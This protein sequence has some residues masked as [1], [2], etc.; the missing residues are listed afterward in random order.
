MISVDQAKEKQTK[1]AFFLAAVCSIGVFLMLQIL[2][3]CGVLQKLAPEMPEISNLAAYVLTLVLF[4][5]AFCTFLLVFRRLPMTKTAA[6]MEGR[7]SDQTYKRTF[8][9]AS[10][11]V[12][13]LLA[14]RRLF[15]EATEF[16][17]MAAAVSFRMFPLWIAIPLF[18]IVAGTAVFFALRLCRGWDISN[19]MLYMCT[20]CVLL[21][22]LIAVL[23]LDLF[24]GDIHHGVAYLESVYNVYYGVPY[25]RITMGI[26]G[27]Y[28]LFLAPVLHIFGGSALPL[29]ITMALL[30]C[31]TALL[32]MYCVWSLVENNC[33]RL[34]SLLMCC[35]CTLSMRPR[36]YWQLLPHRV[37]WPLIL[38]AFLLYLTKKDSWR[39]RD[40]FF[41][42]CL[43]TAA[44]VWNMESGLF[45]GIAFAAACMVRDWQ[46]RVWYSPKSLLKL[47][48][49]I[50][51]VIAT[52]AAAILIVNGYNYLCGQREWFLK[53]FFF[54]M[55][56]SSY[57]SDLL[58][59]DMPIGNHAWV[60]V[61]ILFG[62]LL[63]C[64]LYM[65]SFV[66]GKP[67]TAT[68]EA[69]KLAPVMMAVAMLGLCCF[70][71]YA[72]RAAYG[73]LEI[74]IQLAGIA[75]CMLWREFRKSL[76]QR[77]GT[78]EDCVKTIIS[79][80]STVL[81]ITLS[82]EAVLFSAPLLLRKLMYQHYD[83]RGYRQA[84]V[85]LQETI[86]E[87]TFAFGG[88]I[89]MMYAELGWDPV[90]HYRDASDYRV[91][92]GEPIGAIVEDVLE[93]DA[94]A[95][96]VSTGREEEVLERILAEEPDF[97][98]EKEVELNGKPLQYYI[99]AGK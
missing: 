96:Y 34:C 10:G 77:S 68:A 38:V 40:V 71:Y 26:Y 19:R 88:G 49:H 8:T 67:D 97:C 95:V 63:L 17:S 84:C 73:C 39:K 35:L 69:A 53:D 54:P 94:F 82:I 61:L 37:L 76:S 83:T 18:M 9:A 33:F 70:S 43:C 87:N 59:V 93:Q 55:F 29:M 48:M 51:C 56:E 81:V 2:L 44:V 65:T 30:Q 21:L 24:H 7:L 31:V 85:Q 60:Y 50:C 75:I 12:L 41:G 15:S 4:V 3:P 42:Y 89:A 57:M 11:V 86:P 79:Y 20:G 47:L 46:R 92:G 32:C 14:V 74:I 72:N 13:L 58:E 16:A 64:A 1:W 6:F 98:L 23:V 5:A 90:G 22:N 25:N 45:C 28:G 66:H 91:G 99:R 27:F 78:R 36:N 80:V 62:A 52:V